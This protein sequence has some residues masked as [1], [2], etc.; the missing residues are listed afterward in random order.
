MPAP[1]PPLTV[2]TL[3]RSGL[4]VAGLLFLGVGFGDSIAG[5]VKIAQYQEVLRTSE[6]RAPRDPA[7]LF[8][9]ASEGQERYDLARAKLAFYQLLLTAGQLLTA[10]GFALLAIGVL[11]VRLRPP[12]A[13]Q[14]SRAL[15]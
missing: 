2:H 1:T 9:T 8:P 11:R 12:Q 13:A 10:L 5:H 14:E 15:H 4:F 3:M 7:A 6:P